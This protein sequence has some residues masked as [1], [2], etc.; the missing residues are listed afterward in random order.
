MNGKI[1][2]SMLS[3]SDDPSSG[4]ASYAH[5]VPSLHM[6]NGPVILEKATNERKEEISLSNFTVSICICISILQFLLLNDAVWP[7]RNDY[8]LA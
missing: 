7:R 4:C 5:R 3:Q 1:I 8:G 6:N 2:I